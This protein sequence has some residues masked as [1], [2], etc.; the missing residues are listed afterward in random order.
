MLDVLLD[1]ID[2]VR[3]NRMFTIDFIL[4]GYLQLLVS[5]LFIIQRNAVPL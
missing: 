4:L 1:V 3:C 5:S 2:D